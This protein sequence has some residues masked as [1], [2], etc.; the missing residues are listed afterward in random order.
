MGPKSFITCYVCFKKFGSKFVAFHEPKCLERW[1]SSNKNL[2]NDKRTPTTPVKP[3]VVCNDNTPDDWSCDTNSDNYPQS[4]DRYLNAKNLQSSENDLK[5]EKLQFGD[6]HSHVKNLQSSNKYSNLKSSNNISN[7]TGVVKAEF[8]PK[9]GKE[10]KNSS[11]NH[12]PVPSVVRKNAR[13]DSKDNDDKSA[14]VYYEVVE[15]TSTSDRSVR[16]QTKILRRPTP[17]LNH[18]VIQFDSDDSSGD[19]SCSDKSKDDN[20]KRLKMG[21]DSDGDKPKNFILY[22]KN[23]VEK[24]TIK[25]SPKERAS[26]NNA[27]PPPIIP[28][29]CNSCN[30]SLAPERLHSHA[31]KDSRGLMYRKS[32][33]LDLK[34]EATSA[35]QKS[36]EK[37]PTMASSQHKIPEIISKSP[38][39][40]VKMASPHQ[41]IPEILSKSPNTDVKMASPRKKV[42]EHSE[43]AIKMAATSPQQ[44]LSKLPKPPSLEIKPIHHPKIPTPDAHSNK[45]LTSNGKAIPKLTKLDKPTADADAQQ[46]QIES[47]DKP[48][49]LDTKVATPKKKVSRSNPYRVLNKIPVQKELLKSSEKD[50]TEDT[51]VDSLTVPESAPKAKDDQEIEKACYICFKVFKASVLMLHE[52]RCL[53]HWKRGNNSLTPNLRQLPPRRPATS[54]DDDE[55]DDDLVCTSMES[56]LVPCDLCG[57]TFFPERLPVHSRVCKSKSSPS[58]LKRAA[59]LRER[60]ASSTEGEEVKSAVYVP[61]YVCGRN[62]GSWVISMHEQQ[63]LKKWRRENDKLPDEERKEEPQ[64][65]PESPGK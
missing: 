60:S 5:A 57:R 65:Y 49:H 38:N 47:S 31:K 50:I 33:S 2:P 30:R 39:K 14:A 58:P 34:I 16:P 12:I 17:N 28:N 44:K 35:Q 20:P 8:S 55:F 23:N 32:P 4:S 64:K 61:C 45:P 43:N 18:P 13:N 46:K 63:C 48:Q 37:S 3:T 11:N 22:N 15:V 9:K 53:E 24:N 1:R 25:S 29:P 26:T 62:Y 36:A 59:S 51:S 7:M 54:D 6:R 21:S 10:N 42:S 27:A 19:S 56:Q 40:D 41:K 52:S